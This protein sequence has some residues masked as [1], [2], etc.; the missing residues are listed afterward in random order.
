[1]PPYAQRQ[2]GGSTSILLK[3]AFERDYVS[4]LVRGL[5]ADKL[6]IM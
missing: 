1:M 2:P 4:C 3:Q 5:M 6:G